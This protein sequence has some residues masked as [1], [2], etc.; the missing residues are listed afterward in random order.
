MSKIATDAPQYRK[1]YSNRVSLCDLREQDLLHYLENEKLSAPKM[2]KLV[3]ALRE[4][5]KKR[6]EAKVMQEY[7]THLCPDQ[8][9][10]RKLVLR[11]LREIN[12]QDKYKVRTDILK[13]V[14]GDERKELK[15]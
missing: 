8:N 6:R 5:R 1:E 10:S 12:V 15:F 14:F 13:E 7:V 4:N 11:S 2:A 9:V 3:V